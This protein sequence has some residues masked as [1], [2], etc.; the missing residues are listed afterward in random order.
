MIRAAVYK[1]LQDKETGQSPC[2][3]LSEKYIKTFYLKFL[4]IGE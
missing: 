1:L 2:F 4:Y 3:L